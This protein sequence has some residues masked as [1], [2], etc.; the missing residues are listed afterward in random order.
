M[1]SLDI[2]SQLN[3]KEHPEGGFYAETYRSHF[4]SLNQE[5]CSRNL[6]TIIYYL[7]EANDISCFH[8]L[9]SDEIWFFHQGEPLEVIMIVE[10]KIQK[11]LL[12]ND[13]QNSQLPQLIIPAGVWFAA[14][15]KSQKNYSFV[16]CVVTPG[17]DF[18]DFEMANRNQ[19]IT[20]FPDLSEIIIEFTK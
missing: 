4:K 20:E 5:N 10:G 3:L 2:I 17:F 13:L 16:S 7:L 14:K 18:Q 15:V 6:S 12:G 19:L 1:N 9:K 11:F 8:R